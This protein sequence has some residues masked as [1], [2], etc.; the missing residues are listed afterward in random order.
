MTDHR[1]VTWGEALVVEAFK[2]SGGLRAAVDA[3]HA[4]VGPHIGSRN[5]FAKLFKSDSPEALADVDRFRAWLLLATFGQ[6]PADWGIPDGVVPKAFDQG[7][8]RSALGTHD[9]G[10]SATR[11]YLQAVA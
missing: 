8:L 3:I 7:E 4:E 1:L 6:D 11:R 9:R 2:M 10:A 5:T